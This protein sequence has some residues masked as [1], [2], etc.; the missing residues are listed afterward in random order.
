MKTMKTLIYKVWMLI[1]INL[2]L[3]SNG[4]IWIE[5][6]HLIYGHT[7]N[8]AFKVPLNTKM[9][10]P[11]ELCS[12]CQNSIM[13]LT[14]RLTNKWTQFAHKWYMS[15]SREFLE[16]SLM[17]VSQVRTSPRLS[18]SFWNLLSYMM[19]L[20]SEMTS[21]WNSSLIL[22]WDLISSSLDRGLY[23]KII[24]YKY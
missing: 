4:Y 13:I 9:R 6:I 12:F 3:S 16:E 11:I 17:T 24:Q 7:F 1:K 10:N 19:E 18:K 8:K 21:N 20:I 15:V 23:W 2:F 22:L 14:L 5:I